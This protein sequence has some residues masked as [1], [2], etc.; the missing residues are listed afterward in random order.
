M[1]GFLM[2]DSFYD[3]LSSIS[4]SLAVEASVGPRR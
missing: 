4:L 3:E 2:C 1:L